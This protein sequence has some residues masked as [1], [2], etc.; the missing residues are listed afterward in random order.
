[1]EQ[2]RSQSDQVKEIV[3]ELARL[4]K[5]YDEKQAVLRRKLCEL[6]SSGPRTPQREIVKKVVEFFLFEK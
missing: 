4:Q 2:P 1:M 6:F 3:T 5:E